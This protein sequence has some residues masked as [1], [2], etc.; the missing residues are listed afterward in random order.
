MC[1]NRQ[2]GGVYVG[3]DTVGRYGSQSLWRFLIEEEMFIGQE[4]GWRGGV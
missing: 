3:T 4:E 1:S 2:E